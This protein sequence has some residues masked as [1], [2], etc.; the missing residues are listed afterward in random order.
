MVVTDDEALYKLMLS[1][2]AHGW[3]RDWP[4]NS[5]SDN[6]C[7]V[8]PGYNVRP[9]ELAGALGLSQLDRLESILAGRMKNAGEFLKLMEDH[10][11]IRIQKVKAG[12]SSWYS[13]TM[14]LP[15]SFP[16]A[17]DHLMKSLRDSGIES[18]LIT[19]GCF[20]RHPMREHFDFSTSGDLTQAKMAHDRG[21][22]V[23]NHAVEMGDMFSVLNRVLKEIQR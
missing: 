20:L 1:L 4:E 14:I 8:V 3:T 16:C 15:E 13:F 18:R 21:L 10:S 12:V 2:R 7:F 5:S 6:Y 17:R 22:F 19:G 23:A 11:Q 9:L